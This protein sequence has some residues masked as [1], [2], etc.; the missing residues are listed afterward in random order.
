MAFNVGDLVIWK[1]TQELGIVLDKHNGFYSE[2]EDS[3]LVKFIETTSKTTG[4]KWYSARNFILA[5][6]RL[7]VK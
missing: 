6:E 4:I 7:S 5:D 3:V 1:G 2:H